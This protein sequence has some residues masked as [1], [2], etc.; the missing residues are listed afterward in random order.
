MRKIALLI[1][2]GEYSSSKLANLPQAE[3][4]ADDLYRVLVDPKL[5]EFSAKN[6]ELLK[7]PNKREMEQKIDWLF[8]DRKKDD[9]LLFYFA[10]HGVLDDKDH[11]YLT[12]NDTYMKADGRLNTF[13]A[14][15]SSYLLQYINASKSDRKVIILDACYSGAIAQGLVGR[16]TTGAKLKESFG[17]KGSVILASSSSTERTWDGIYTQCLV[18]GIQTGAADLDRDGWISLEDLHN[19]VVDRVGAASSKMT[20]TPRFIPVEDRGHS[21]RLTKSPTDLKLKYERLL[22]EEYSDENWGELSDFVRS[23]LLEKQQEWGISSAEAEIIEARVLLYQNKL[24]EYEQGLTN[25]I[26]K[27]YPISARFQ[28]KL[29][30]FQKYFKLRDE[31]IAEIHRRVLPPA[32][33]APSAPISKPEPITPPPAAKIPIIPPTSILKPKTVAPPP[34]PTIITPPPAAK[35][36]IIPP[37]PIPKPEPVAPPLAQNIISLSTFSFETAQVKLVSG[38]IEITKSPGSAQHFVEELGNGVKLEMVYV[39]DGEFMMGSDA[40]PADEKPR[41]R[42]NVPPFLMSKYPVTQAQYQ[43]II[44]SNPS[45]FKGPQ[46]PVEWVSWHDAQAFCQKLANKTNKAY[47]LPSEAEWEYA[48]RAGTKTPF[49]FG[50]TISPDVVNCNGNYPYGKAPKGVYRESTTDVGIFPANSFG[51]YDLHGNVWEW[52]LDTGHENYQ[53]APTDGSA[54]ID[55]NNDSRMLRGG[56]WLNYA[57]HCRSASRLMFT[58]DGRDDTFGFRLVLSP[59]PGLP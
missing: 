21:I 7:S 13:S 40:Y 52:C 9:L 56:D 35:I 16:G 6:I 27:Q 58:P 41:H 59:S 19:Y 30:E 1:G 33:T 31:D 24:I 23:I 18:E 22:Q 36:P 57:Q 54:W 34:T 5:G 43:S 17:G 4:D 47:R 51:L 32:P 15:D 26:Q 46:R 50:E 45:R 10:G 37:A 3:Q 53:A 12:A 42:V 38:K 55:K 25:A 48:C 44:G 20:M 49:Y 2:M 28:A 8:D 39:P 29:T 11:L 14:I